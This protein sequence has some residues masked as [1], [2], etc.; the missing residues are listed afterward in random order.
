MKQRSEIESR[1]RADTADLVRF[2]HDDCAA[3]LF[4]GRFNG[5]HVQRN[6]GARVDDL[7]ADTLFLKALGDVDS[8]LYIGMRAYDG[9]ILAFADDLCLAER[10]AVVRIV[11]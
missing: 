3:R 10:D 4:H 2:V 1:S 7:D 5:I 9:D 11:V 6:D 8:L